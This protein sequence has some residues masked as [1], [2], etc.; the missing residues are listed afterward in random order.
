MHSARRHGIAIAACSDRC[1]REATHFR[2]AQ[3]NQRRGEPVAAATLL[4][5]T[6]DRL[7][8]GIGRCAPRG[9]LRGRMRGA[10]RLDGPARGDQ[11]RRTVDLDKGHAL[12]R[13]REPTH[14]NDHTL[15]A[16]LPA[17]GRSDG[18]VQGI[19]LGL[20]LG[21][22]PSLELTRALETPELLA[23]APRC[24]RMD[25]RRRHGLEHRGDLSRRK[26]RVAFD[27]EEDRLADQGGMHRVEHF[28]ARE[29]APCKRLASSLQPEGL[30]RGRRTAR[31]RGHRRGTQACIDGRALRSLPA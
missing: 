8:H 24:A 7:Q 1:A 11:P 20:R 22:P 31:D 17:L 13:G 29:V 19:D 28:V 3:R 6:R 18:V 5:R 4:P 16:R 23:H 26:H 12:R 15:E 9:W 10:R 21:Q 30:P 2:R 14:R 27:G 25:D